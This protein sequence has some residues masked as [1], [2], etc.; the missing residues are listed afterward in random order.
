MTLRASPSLV[1]N[2]T[3]LLNAAPVGG[4]IAI[5]YQHESIHV[6]N[7][8]IAHSTEG[9]AV[10]CVPEAIPSISCC[11]I[12]G[13]AGGDWIGLIQSQYG[14]DGNIS[15]DPHFCGSTWN[16]YVPWL[17]H[18]ASPCAPFSPPNT[19]C[20]L[21]GAWPVGCGGLAGMSSDVPKSRP[22]VDVYPNP[23]SSALNFYYHSIDTSIRGTLSIRILD[24]SGRGIRTLTLRRQTEGCEAAT[25]DGRDANGALSPTGVYYYQVVGDGFRS[26]G[27]V[28]LLR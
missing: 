2:C 27:T 10:F 23:F 7:T 12:Y 5:D 3:M 17:L 26:G 15:E 4:G 18:A 14:I 11:D 20:D 19:E 1:S 16:P 22:C 21:I 28:R 13:N 9:E 6:E 8:I 24:I 25:W